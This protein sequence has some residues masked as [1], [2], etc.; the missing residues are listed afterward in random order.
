M[1]SSIKGKEHKMKYEID[2]SSAYNPDDIH[3][4]I[5]EVLPL[6]EYYGGNLDALHDVL[7]DIFEETQISF[8]NTYEAWVMMPRYMAGLKRLCLDVAKENPNL[9]IEFDY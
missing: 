4:I 6:P 2:L 9:H 3:E 5:A 1:S 8:I 7:T